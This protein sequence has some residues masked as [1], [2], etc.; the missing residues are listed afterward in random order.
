MNRVYKGLT[1][2]SKE[3]EKKPATHVI[4]TVE[5]YDKLLRDISNA[6]EETRITARNSRIEISQNK[7]QTDKLIKQE[8]EEAQKRIEAVQ[9]DFNRA[10]AEIH[11]LNDL[12]AN[13]LRIAKERANSKRGLKPKKTHHGYMVLDSQQYNYTFRYW[14]QGKGYS[15]EFPCWKVRIQSPYDSSI[16]YETITK[17]IT[18]DLVKIFGSSLGISSIYSDLSKFN[19]KQVKELWENEKNFIF[20]TSYKANIK[21]GLWEIEYLVKSSIK[22][23]EDMRT[24]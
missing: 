21:S 6:Q 14:V 12:N 18:N 1:G 5:E 20:K 24:A 10:K 15:D 13:M 2:Y 9:S 17:N 8:R 23:P 22:V 11:R 16:P 7:E 3:T 4:L 19:A